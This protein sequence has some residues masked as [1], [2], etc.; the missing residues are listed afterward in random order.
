MAVQVQL[1]VVKVAGG[2]S[3]TSTPVAL[4]ALL[5]LTVMVKLAVPPGITAVCSVVLLTEIW[6]GGNTVKLALAGA[7]LAPPS[8]TNAPAGSVLVS[9]CDVLVSICTSTSIVQPVVPGRVEPLGS[10]MVDAPPIAVTVPVQ[11]EARFGVLA[12]VIPAGR[13]STKS[14]VV[15]RAPVKPPVV[16]PV[17]ARVSVRRLVAMPL[18]KAALAGL[19][20][21][22]RVGGS[23]L[24]SRIP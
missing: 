6:G 19:R 17:L 15:I 24:A 13:V 18:L 12:T 1:T 2:I 21:L 16:L 5:L 11:V 22:L 8:V 9:T 20:A 7:T 23:I 4:L 10:V 3:V 14:A